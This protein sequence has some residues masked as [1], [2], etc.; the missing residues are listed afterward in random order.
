MRCPNCGVGD[1]R[2]LDTRPVQENR[3]IRRRR[4]CFSCHQRFTTYERLEETPLWV[5][6]KDGRREIF[7]RHKIL[8]GLLTACEKR[9][10]P[11]GALETLA[12]AVERE[13]RQTHEGEVPTVA[14]GEEVIARLR[15]VDEVAYVRFASV[16]RQ[17]TDLKGF[18][19]ELEELLNQSP[20]H[21]K[22]RPHGV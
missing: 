20:K 4:E 13:I 8:K 11:L 7:D 3:E 12:E 10:V 1:T 16:Y 19:E 5:V 14:I 21:G 18:R 22:E 9:P 17:F 15:H 6:K 2:V